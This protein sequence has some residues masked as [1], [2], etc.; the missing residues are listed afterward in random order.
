MPLAVETSAVEFG[1]DASI[2]SSSLSRLS[3]SGAILLSM[4][5]PDSMAVAIRSIFDGSSY[6]E[7]A[8][9]N[10]CKAIPMPMNSNTSPHKRTTILNT[11]RVAVSNDSIAGFS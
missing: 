3:R 11:S 4:L 6:R 10:T 2:F 7:S 9:L 1:V 5:E 8:S